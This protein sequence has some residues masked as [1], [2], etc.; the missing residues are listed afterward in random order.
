VPIALS[1]MSPVAPA[2]SPVPP[3]IAS[4]ESPLSRNGPSTV[5]WPLSKESVQKHSHALPGKGAEADALVGANLVLIV[6]VEHLVGEGEDIAGAVSRRARVGDGVGRGLL[7]HLYFLRL[8][9]RSR[10]RRDKAAGGDTE[11]AQIWQQ[12]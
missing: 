4:T 8:G 3:V 6:G 1:A 9:N 5:I 12:I 7:H 2:N 11:Q 10:T